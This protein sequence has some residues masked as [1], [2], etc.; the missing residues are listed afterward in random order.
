MKNVSGFNFKKNLLTYLSWTTGAVQEVWP[1]V[2]AFVYSI[3][4]FVMI[5]VLNILIMR[6]V[7]RDVRSNW[8]TR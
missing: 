8:T 3:I 2:D 6:Q 5:L 1:W 7:S 4:P